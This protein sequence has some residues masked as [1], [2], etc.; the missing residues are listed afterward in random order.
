M[1]NTVTRRGSGVTPIDIALRAATKNHNEVKQSRWIGQMVLACATI[2]DLVV[3]ILL[4]VRLS[5]CVCT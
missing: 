4:K 2:G 1:H 5:L 3:K